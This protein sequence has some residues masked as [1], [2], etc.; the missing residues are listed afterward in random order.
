MPLRTAL[1]P[2]VAALVLALA[3]LSLP[4]QALA[5]DELN[6][7]YVEA[8]YRSGEI[9]VSGQDVDFTALGGV[10]SYELTENFALFG[11]GFTGEIE[12]TD[13][14]ALKDIDTR[15][16]SAGLTAHFPL[17]RNIDL[18]VPMAIAY[19]RTRAG[20]AINSDT[21]YAIAVGVRALLTDNI[22]LAGG[23]QHV[24]IEDDE[25]SITGTVRFHFSDAISV[26][27][28]ASAGDDTDSLGVGARFSF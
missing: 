14:G 21:G 16:L 27:L 4:G 26:S 2:T 5:V 23:V 7:S 17:S 28:S 13:S 22:E 20:N 19:A 3:A 11:S 6:Y 15:E 18:V 10:V 24:D 8:G 25:Q 1:I 12:T 9:D